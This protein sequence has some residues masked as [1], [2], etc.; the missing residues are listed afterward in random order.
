LTIRTDDPGLTAAYERYFPVIRAK[1]TRMLSDPQEA[2]D[3]AQETFI[4]LWQSALIGPD[5]APQQIGA[6]IYRTSTRSAIDRLRQ[7]GRE[8]ALALRSALHAQS[9]P[10]GAAP[11]EAALRAR[12]LLQQ[13]ASEVPHEELEVAILSRLDLLT[14]AEIAEVAA[15]SERTVRRLL[16]RFDERVQ[17][18]P[19]ELAP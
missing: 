15:C 9:A 2:E 11:D 10:F 3:V 13:L 5:V 7:R 16:Q 1:C 19:A 12:R 14:H 4:R 6:W 18:L 8:R 17:H